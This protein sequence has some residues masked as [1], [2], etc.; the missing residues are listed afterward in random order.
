MLNNKQCFPFIVMTIIILN[1][2]F[3]Y[4]YFNLL[5]TFINAQQKFVISLKCN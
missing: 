3:Y 1:I 4:P 5:N 2:E